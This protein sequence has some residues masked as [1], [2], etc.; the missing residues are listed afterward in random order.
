MKSNVT[1]PLRRLQGNKMEAA[2]IEAKPLENKDLQQIGQLL[3]DPGHEAPQ[4]GQ[5]Q[6]FSSGTSEANVQPNNQT[7][8][9]LRT[10]LEHNMSTMEMFQE[11]RLKTV[12]ARWKSLPNEI[13]EAIWTLAIRFGK[14]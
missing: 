10:P 6:E 7:A 4:P 12:A 9:N 2:G 14:E 5:Y 13:R 11:W 3:P 8:T 1:C